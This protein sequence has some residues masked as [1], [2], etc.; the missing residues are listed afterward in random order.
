MKDYKKAVALTYRK[1]V[2]DAPKVLAKGKGLIADQII[3]IARK[4]GVDIYPDRDLVEVLEALDLNTEIPESLYQAVAEVLVF[5]YE[6]N[7]NMQ[8]GGQESGDA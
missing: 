4:S 8:S 1:N 7:K 2:D 3:S 6:I 5:I